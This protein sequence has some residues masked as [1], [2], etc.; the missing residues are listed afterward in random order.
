MDRCSAVRDLRHHCE[1]HAPVHTLALASS[2]ISH[3]HSLGRFDIRPAIDICIILD[4]AWMPVSNQAGVGWILRDPVSL[5]TLGG[6]AQACVLG[7][8][9]QAELLACLYVVRMA[10]RRGYMRILLYSDSAILVRLVFSK[11]IA[12]M[13]VLWLVKDLRSLLSGFRGFSV[14]F[15]VLK[16]SH[17]MIRPAH[18]LAASAHRR[19]LLRHRF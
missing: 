2:A 18:D 3:P 8:A 16:V 14:G 11:C 1:S 5:A 7:C 10:S 6:G 17:S 19:Q 4:G 9:L 15:S 12:P 13:V